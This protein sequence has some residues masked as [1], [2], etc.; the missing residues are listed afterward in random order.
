MLAKTTRDALGDALAA[1]HPAYGFDVQGLLAVS[2]EHREALETHGPCVQHRQFVVHPRRHADTAAALGADVGLS[3]DTAY[4]VESWRRQIHL[5]RPCG[6]DRRRLHDELYGSV[7]DGRLR[8]GLRGAGG[9]HRV[10][11]CSS[12][13][14]S[15]S[16]RSRPGRAI[17][18]DADRHAQARRSLESAGLVTTEKVGRV[19]TCRIGDGRLDEVA[20]WIDSYQRRW[21]ARFDELDKVVAE[22]KLKEEQ[23]GRAKH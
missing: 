19:R 3:D 18:H 11:G 10:E 22:L 2:P 13:S 20:A 6:A 12:S 15:R 1:E 9:R 16:G 21:D 23:D 14:G 8:R 17:R 4:L 7:S 5:R